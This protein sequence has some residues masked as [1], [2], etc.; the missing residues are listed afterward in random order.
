MTKKLLI[1]CVYKAATVLLENNRSF[2][3]A[4]FEKVIL[5]TVSDDKRKGLRYAL[6]K[7]VID[8]SVPDTGSVA[9]AFLSSKDT[10]TKAIGLSMYEKLRYPEL[11]ATVEAIA[12]DTKQGELGN[13]AKKILGNV[14]IVPATL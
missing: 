3:Q 11:T 7:I 4:D 10:Q 5:K 8:K 1:F 12:A 13:R 9:S 2:V 14:K 6:G